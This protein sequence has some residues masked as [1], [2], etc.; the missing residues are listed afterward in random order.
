M[1]H[2]KQAMIASLI[3]KVRAYEVLK[4]EA[5]AVGDD[6]ETRRLQTM[7]DEWRKILE[8]LLAD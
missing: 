3:G 2:I 8:D 7:L 4:K 1:K 6:E 5:E